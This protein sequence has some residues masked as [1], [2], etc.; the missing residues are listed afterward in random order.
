EAQKEMFGIGPGARVMQFASL[1]FDA[2]VSEIF[3]SFAAGASLHVYGRE[4][5]RAGDELV[6][7][8]REDRITTVTLPPSL[9]AALGEIELIELETVIAAGEACTAEIVERWAGGRRFFNAYGPT[10]ATV[11]ASIGEV[12]G[13]AEGK[14]SIGRPIKNTRLYILDGQ[15]N[16]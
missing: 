8:L 2:S 9:L 5:L 7:A 4:S 11:C 10:E 15:M 16:P 14:P 12:K 6:R 1:S 13:G 3:S